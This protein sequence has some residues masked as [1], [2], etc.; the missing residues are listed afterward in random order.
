VQALRDP[1]EQP[2][3]SRTQALREAR[4][5]HVDTKVQALACYE[6]QGHRN[7]TNEDYIRNV[8]L[9]RGIDVGLDFAEVFEV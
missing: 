9:T 6:S 4:K 2:Q 5:S 8:A 3:L 1:L 7:Y